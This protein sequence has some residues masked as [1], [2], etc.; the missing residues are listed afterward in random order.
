MLKFLDKFFQI[1]NFLL[2]LRGV[3]AFLANIQSDSPKEKD[4]DRNWNFS[5]KISF[6]NFNLALTHIYLY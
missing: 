3:L 2:F 6:K 5:C 4:L 1:S